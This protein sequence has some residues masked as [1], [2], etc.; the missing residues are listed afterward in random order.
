MQHVCYGALCSGSDMCV[1]VLGERPLET[2]LQCAADALFG[3]GSKRGPHGGERG[4]ALHTD[5]LQ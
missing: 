5:F 4:H 1:C 3:S 2:E